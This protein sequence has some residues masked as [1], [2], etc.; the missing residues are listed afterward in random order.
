MGFGD[1]LI[2]TAQVMARA[3]GTDA[4]GQQSGEFTVTVAANV[5]CRYEQKDGREIGQ[6]VADGEIVIGSVMMGAGVAVTERHRLT[7]TGPGLASGGVKVLVDAVLPVG[8]HH[9]KVAV[10]ETR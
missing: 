5:P 1:A 2:H 9:L 8:E 3:S 10:H 6:K 4:Y 7:V